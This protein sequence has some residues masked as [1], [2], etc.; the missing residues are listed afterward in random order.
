ML[1]KCR[2]LPV[3]ATGGPTI[4]SVG[5]NP[6]LE[7]SGVSGCNISIVT[8]ECECYL[9]VVSDSI[10]KNGERISVV[11]AAGLSGLESIYYIV[12]SENIAA[13][14]A[15]VLGLEVSSE[16]IYLLA[17]V[18][19]S[20]AV[21]TSLSRKTVYIGSF[22]YSAVLL[23]LGLVPLLVVDAEEVISSS[24][25]VNEVAVSVNNILGSVLL[26]LSCMRAP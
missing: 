23:D 14:C 15:V 8:G 11:V 10:V 18:L 7:E 20:K 16:R 24:V 12:S 21:P 13:C 5:L 19:E 4:S 6:L 26:A 2:R 17:N 1:T 3:C 22:E 25:G 9:L